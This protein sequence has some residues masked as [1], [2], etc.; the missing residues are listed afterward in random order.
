VPPFSDQPMRP[1]PI[2][3]AGR[4]MRDRPPIGQIPIS[5]SF[6]PPLPVNLSLCNARQILAVLVR[7]QGSSGASLQQRTPLSVPP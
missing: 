1:N 6:S 7:S 5:I 4:P 2:L 3:R